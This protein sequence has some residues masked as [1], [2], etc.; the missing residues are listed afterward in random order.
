M[1]GR[2]LGRFWSNSL[3]IEIMHTNMS[4]PMTPTTI[5]LYFGR[6]VE[7]MVALSAICNFGHNSDS[8]CNSNSTFIALNLCQRADSKAQLN[9]NI[10][11][12]S[13]PGT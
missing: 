11:Q 4:T 10:I 7:M 1:G 5:L 9:K 6:N 13:C 3:N 8:N 2:K 12:Y